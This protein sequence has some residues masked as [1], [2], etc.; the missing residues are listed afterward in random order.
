MNGIEL[1]SIISN[2][3]FDIQNVF[4][5]YEILTF[6]NNTIELEE[7]DDKGFFKNKQSNI[8]FSLNRT[9]EFILSSKD[10]KSTD[11]KTILIKLKDSKNE[12]EKLDNKNDIIPEYFSYD[13]I[14][15][16]IFEPNEE[17]FNFKIKEVFKNKKGIKES[18]INR[19]RNRDF[20]EMVSDVSIE[21]ENKEENINI[22]EKKRGRPPPLNYANIGGHNK[23]S[24]D[25]I[26]K[27]IKAEI[28]KYLIIF[29][30]KILNKKN[31]DKDRIFNLDYKY[32]NK[33]KKENDLEYLN[34]PLKKLLSL[35]VSPKHRGTHS[36]VNKENIEKILNMEKNDDTIN[37]VFNMT[38]RDF[39]NVFI[40]KI[41]VPDLIYK[42]TFGKNTNIN[43]EKIK[44]SLEGLDIILNKISEKN[45]SNYFSSFCIFLYNYELWFYNKFGRKREPK[46]KVINI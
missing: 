29:V 25:N 38:F 14:R 42:Y 31:E 35:D 43:S 24:E 44:N 36:E 34:M 16:K 37:F 40:N 19:K 32:I 5:N 6:N 39:F 1:N 3:E 4:N 9:D 15:T 7:K 28:F 18:L 33:L 21:I 13:D 11:I 17:K 41:N 45:D 12:L 23:M 26:I 30:N 22:N 46:P 2:G 27:K 8:T 20:Y 10:E